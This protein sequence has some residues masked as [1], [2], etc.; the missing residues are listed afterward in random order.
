M[1]RKILAGLVVAFVAVWT[2]IALL[3]GPE[4]RLADL[5][6]ELRARGEPVSLVEMEAPFP[7]DAEN[8]APDID[9][10]MAWLEQ[11]QPDGSWESEVAG[12][13][14]VNL[15]SPWQET[16]T[17]EQMAALADLLVRIAPMHALIDRAAEKREI[18]WPLPARDTAAGVLENG[19]PVRLLQDLGQHLSARA[20]G[21]AGSDERLRAIRS[22]LAISARLRVRTMIEHLVAAVMYASACGNLR[23]GLTR[24]T[25]DPAEARRVLDDVLVDTWEARFPDLVRGERAHLLDAFPFWLDGTL[26]AE[27]AKSFGKPP[28]AWERVQHAAK[29][30]LRGRN[31][32]EDGLD[33]L[34]IDDVRA[35]GRYLGPDADAKSTL[36]AR[37]STT[38]SR[39]TVLLPRVRERLIQTDV[40]VRI[41]RLALAAYAHRRLHGAWPSSA[42][43]LAPLLGGDV[44]HHPFTG[45]PFV[46]ERDG[47]SDVLVVRARPWNGAVFGSVDDPEEELG[48]VWRLPPR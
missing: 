20:L 5:I 30:L 1:R 17:P 22:G 8:G 23:D 19:I 41:A 10:A 15:L 13:W 45:E 28:G 35:L 29:Q 33:D 46:L 2:C 40:S 44:P 24:G 26:E 6:A 25:L 48:H 16:A 11:N 32:F 31:P 47:E 14:N 7:P 4:E 21:A 34:T 36:E 39:L 43:D 37:D 42:D 3:P 38:R 12:P 9:A 18:A 27:L